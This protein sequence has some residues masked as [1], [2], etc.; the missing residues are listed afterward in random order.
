MTVAFVFQGGSS[1]AAVQVGMLR[2]L[3]DA[4]IRPDLVV[5]S[6][7]GAINAV[8]FAQNPTLDGISD[9]QR[10]WNGLRRRDVFPMSPRA[11]LR[12]L[13][14]RG[15]SLVKPGR[16]RSLLER[17]VRVRDLRETAVPVHVVA[18]HAGTGRP[19]VLSAGPAVDALLASSSIPGVLPPVSWHG[20]P[21]IDGGVSADVPILQAEALGA[22][23]SYVLPSLVDAP[24]DGPTAGALP[25][26]M[27]SMGMLLE[28]TSDH[29]LAAARGDVHVLPVPPLHDLNPFDFRH[30]GEY[31]RI[32]YD[33]TRGW[34]SRHPAAAKVPELVPA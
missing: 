26:L 3:V 11:L 23:T 27:R 2:A 21:L 32:G 28:R 20:K 5:G 30:G 33:S 9:M 12:G 16:L 17:E 8:A 13:S 1:L 6:S 34:L 18:T 22:T 4:G 19:E 14:G 29:D 31:I 25:L 24:A 15:D 10:L 7:A